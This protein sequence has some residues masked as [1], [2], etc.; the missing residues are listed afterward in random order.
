MGRKRRTKNWFWIQVN[1][2]TIK[3]YLW[4]QIILL[5]IDFL[6]L[7]FNFHNLKFYRMKLKMNESQIE[8]SFQI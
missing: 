1:L 3:K 6:L 4:H 7:K 5:L 2:A 8:D